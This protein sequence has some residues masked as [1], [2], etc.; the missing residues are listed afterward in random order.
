[1]SNTLDDA[2]VA[3][4]ETP[5]GDVIRVWM[6][7]RVSGCVWQVDMFAGNGSVLYVVSLIR[8]SG[9]LSLFS[10]FGLPKTA[11]RIMIFFCCDSA[12]HI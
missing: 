6:L 1:M 4:L 3:K 2:Y 12:F 7:E 5:R 11:L 9:R 8:L 10:C